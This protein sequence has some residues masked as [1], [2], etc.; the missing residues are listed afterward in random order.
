MNFHHLL[1]S[2]MKL[3]QSAQKRCYMA[4]LY[5]LKKWLLLM[6]CC[7]ACD[8]C[9]MLSLL[10]L[11]KLLLNDMLLTRLALNGVLLTSLLLLLVSFVCLSKVLSNLAIYAAYKTKKKLC[12]SEVPAH[13]TSLQRSL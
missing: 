6:S 11:S 8:C 4:K 1:A 7:R 2:L 3:M 10:P 9:L 13:T 12:C 5:P